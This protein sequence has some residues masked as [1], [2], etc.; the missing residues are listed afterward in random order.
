MSRIRVEKNQAKTRS[1]D[2]L[3]TWILFKSRLFYT[4]DI[5]Y[6]RVSVSFSWR[7]YL[8][9]TGSSSV[10]KWTCLWTETVAML[11]HERL[12]YIGEPIFKNSYFRQMDPS[13]LSRILHIF[14][15]V[16]SG[17]YL[18]RVCFVIFLV[19]VAFVL[20][21]LLG[22]LLEKLRRFLMRR[23]LVVHPVNDGGD[24]V[25]FGLNLAFG[26]A[27][28]TFTALLAWELHD[29]STWILHTE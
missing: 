15:H 13:F 21:S 17:D 27:N 28:L 8:G 10:P 11:V 20:N 16:Q 25:A 24:E 29:L 1:N 7:M 18:K 12:N 26:L 19:F 14:D 3:K 4:F 2:V 9:T 5:Q 6:C 22:R 23:M